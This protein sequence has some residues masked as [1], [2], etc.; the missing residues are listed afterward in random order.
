MG[1]LADALAA[2]RTPEKMQV[3]SADP[4]KA[5]SPRAG[6]ARATRPARQPARFAPGAQHTVPKRSHQTSPSPCR[7]F[8]L[9]GRGQDDGADQEHVLWR[10]RGQQRLDRAAGTCAA[11][12]S[13]AHTP[14]LA[15]GRPV[16]PHADRLVWSIRSAP[17][18]AA[19]PVAGARAPRLSFL[20][21]PRLALTRG[22][23]PRSRPTRARLPACARARPRR[24]VRS[25]TSPFSRCS[26]AS[27]RSAGWLGS[28][29]TTRPT[30]SRG[31]AGRWCTCAW[32]SAPSATPSSTSST[33]N[34][35]RGR[36]DRARADRRAPNRG[37]SHRR[38]HRSGGNREW[39]V[40][41]SAPPGR[42]GASWRHARDGVTR[43]SALQAGGIREAAR[44]RMGAGGFCAAAS[45]LWLSDVRLS[46]VIVR[47]SLDGR[48]ARHRET[49]RELARRSERDRGALCFLSKQPRSLARSLSTQ[50]LQ[51]LTP[52]PS[53]ARPALPA[54]LHSSRRPAPRRARRAPRRRPRRRPPRRGGALARSQR[55]VRRGPRPFRTR[56]A[57]CCGGT[58]HV[59]CASTSVRA[60]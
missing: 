9:A 36:T 56:H 27:R 30:S 26:R 11:R 13:G 39:S 23:H 32:P 10:L 25:S 45:G 5:A 3:R 8:S 7:E 51:Q 42:I 55:A 48:R 16:C 2:V 33:C 34:V 28:R 38:A 12:P 20:P 35:R 59:A 40:A 4:A 60:R 41:V 6:R 1:R 17:R 22:L 53:C 57:L 14:P 37:V 44:E 43:R 24:P 47:R 49:E 18:S 58:W 52:T 15:S 29:T 54:C 19:R 46:E 21:P 50:P 31:R